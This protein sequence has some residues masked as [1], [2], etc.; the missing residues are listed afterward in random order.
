MTS[1]KSCA[2]RSAIGWKKCYLLRTTDQWSYGLDNQGAVAQFV[3]R[4]VAI[5]GTLNSS[6]DLIYIHDIQPIP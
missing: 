2:H 3:D 5:T 4:Q 6:H 1:W